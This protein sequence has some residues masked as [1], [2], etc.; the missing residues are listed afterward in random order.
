MENTLTKQV[1][2]SDKLIDGLSKGHKMEKIYVQ[3]QI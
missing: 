1:R 3:S 2:Y